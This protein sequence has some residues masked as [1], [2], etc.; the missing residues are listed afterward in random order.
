M[1]RV[2]VYCEGISEETFINRMLGPELAVHGVFLRAIPFRGVS[3][4]SKLKKS[5]LD[6]CRHDSEAIVTT[7]IDYYGLPSETPGY[8][9]WPNLD[10]Y[11]QV[12]RTEQAIAADIGADNLFPYIMMHEFE[13]MLFSEPQCFSLC[14]M[15]K[16][17]I[18]VMQS[19]KA[20]YPTPEHINNS[21]NTAPS[22]RILHIYPQY[23]KVADGY[24]I[25]VG[26]GLAAIRRECRHVDKWIKWLEGL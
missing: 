24:N 2:N 6:L 10:I 1:R 14:G 8:Q 4:Y 15:D 11:Q 18:R 9:Q 3:K 20:S 19:I 25:A 13:A 12:E 16:Q 5:L 23:N 7:M 26:I 17:A 21:K 22:K